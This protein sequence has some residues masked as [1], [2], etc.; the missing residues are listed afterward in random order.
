MVINA[1]AK[2]QQY[3]QTLDASPV[4][5]YIQEVANKISE[6]YNEIMYIPEKYGP[7]NLPSLPALSASPAIAPHTTTPSTSSTDSFDGSQKFDDIEGVWAP[8][9]P[10][11]E[12]AE[13]GL[14][15]SE[16]LQIEQNVYNPALS[17]EERGRWALM[18]MF[19][20]RGKPCL[21]TVVLESGIERMFKVMLTRHKRWSERVPT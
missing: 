13:D 20:T 15:F 18:M 7:L 1:H 16:F 21:P 19:G 4:D 5:P 14:T 10:P 17:R 11:E 3:I 12:P 8:A 9:E 6:L 2:L